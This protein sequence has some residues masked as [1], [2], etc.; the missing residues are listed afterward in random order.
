MRNLLQAASDL[1]GRRIE[2]AEQARVSGAGVPDLAVLVDELLSGHIELKAPG[3]GADPA[4]FRGHDKEQAERFKVL[5]NLLYTD[6]RDFTLWRDGEMVAAAH[7][8][9]DP[10]REGSAAVEDRDVAQ[11]EG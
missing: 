2:C 6:S 5:P 4:R 9:R 7:L 3:K 8:S 1:L 10:D 11:I